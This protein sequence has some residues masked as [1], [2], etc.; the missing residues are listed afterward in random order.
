MK[1]GLPYVHKT[2]IYEDHKVGKIPHPVF[3]LPMAPQMV[4]QFHVP[5]HAYI[6]ILIS[7][8]F[9]LMLIHTICLAS[10]STIPS[11]VSCCIFHSW[12]QVCRW[13]L[14][15]LGS[16]CNKTN[17]N[18][19]SWIGSRTWKKIIVRT[20]LGQQMKKEQSTKI[21]V[22]MVKNKQTKNNLPPQGER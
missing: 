21:T 12:L 3:P 9:G 18:M 8:P 4:W 1:T 11:S 17:W 5:T 6:S 2:D 13:R 10:G 7:S 22:S 16:Y 19:Q 15:R 20:L 14:P